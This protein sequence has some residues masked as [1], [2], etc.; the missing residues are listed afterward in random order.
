MVDVLEASLKNEIQRIFD[1]SD[2]W[3]M[4]CL[5]DIFTGGLH[6]NERAASIEGFF[7]TQHKYEHSMA[8]VIELSKRLA[9]RECCLET[10]SKEA[11]SYLLHPVYVQMKKRFSP[12][13]LSLMLH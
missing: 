11:H 10:N 4:R 5:D 3:S 8:D 13:A 9:Q 7:K 12:Y 2:K 6:S 1:H